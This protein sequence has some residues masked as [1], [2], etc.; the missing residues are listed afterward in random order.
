M[1]VVFLY[2]YFILFFWSPFPAL[3]IYLLAIGCVFPEAAVLHYSTFAPVV[4]VIFSGVVGE[5][6][7]TLAHQ[8]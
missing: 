3:H 8:W 5:N 1:A 2:L 6:Q 7:A 4:D